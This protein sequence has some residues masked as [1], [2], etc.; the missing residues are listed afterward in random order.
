MAAGLV[1][2]QDAA[3][4]PIGPLREL[5]P[6]WVPTWSIQLA[7]SLFVLVLAYVG[8][9]LVVR[10]F[11][12]RLAQH[13]KRPSLTRTAV[14]GI[15]AGV[16]VLAFFVV[17]GI[18]GMGLEDITLQVT[19]LT[20]V[21][22]VILAP[23]VSNVISG[24][25]LLADQPYEIGDMIQLDEDGKRGYVEDITLRYTKVFTLDNTFL[26]IPNETI[27]ERDVFNYS[28]EDPRTRLS[29][30]ILVTYESDLPQARRRIEAA[31][32]GVEGVIEGGP[33][34]R[35]GGARYPA[36]PTCL[37]ERFAD[38]GIS[39]NLRFWVPEPYRIPTVRSTVQERV[40]DEIQEIDAE[41][42]Y[43][44][45][46]LVFDETSGELDVRGLGGGDGRPQGRSEGPRRVRRDREEGPPRD[47]STADAPSEDG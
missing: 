4:S 9:R 2:L 47:G 17:L 1:V 5:F 15:R 21:I 28:A 41:F 24:V 38:H 26:V 43:P 7:L 11:G 44:H 16:F 40:Y 6:T 29:L 46:H 3:S 36:A 30:P 22:G 10:L 27:R 31:T 23:I 14:R 25:F 37:V 20:A 13:F 19:V 33:G 12:R 18:Y 45:S 35:V 34:I 39:L 32:R 42:A 8:S